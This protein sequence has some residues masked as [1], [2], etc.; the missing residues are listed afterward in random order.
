M[1]IE[2]ENDLETGMKFLVKAE[3]GFKAIYL[4]TGPLPLRLRDEGFAALLSAII[5]QQLSV[6]SAT[7]IKGRL[8]DIG[9]FEPETLLK[10]KD[11]ELRTVGMSAQKTRYARALAEAD[12]PYK[13]FR[14]YDNEEVIASLT[15]VTGIGRWT[16]DIYLMFSLGRADAFASGDLA[17]QESAKVVFDLPDRPTAKQLETMSQKWS[18]WRSVAARLLWSYYQVVKDREGI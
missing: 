7:A 6:A 15:A 12:L 3:P 14:K 18:P 1:T 9:G 2:T 11:N 5:S 8:K 13:A 10:L 16:A 17:L 4:Q